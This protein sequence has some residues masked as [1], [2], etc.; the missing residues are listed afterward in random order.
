MLTENDK[1]DKDQ[2]KLSSISTKD[3]KWDLQKKQTQNVAN[4]YAKTAKFARYAER[5][6]ECADFLLFEIQDQQLKLQSARFCHVR[7]CPICQWRKSLRWKAIMYD[8]YSKIK[9]QYPSHRWLFLTLTVKNC[10]ITE[11]RQTLQHMNQSFRRLI[12]RKQFSFIDGVIRTTEVTRDKKHP[13]THAH[14]HFHCILLV[15]SGYFSHSYVKHDQWRWAWHEALRSDYLPSV[16]IRAIKNHNDDKAINGAIAETLKY[17]IKASDIL[18]DGSDAAR[19]WFYEYTKQ[20]HK[21]RFVA[22]S[23]ALKDVLSDEDL[24]DDEMVHI[25]EKDAETQNNASER[26]VFAYSRHQAHYVY[27]AHMTAMVN[28]PPP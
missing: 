17:A 9:A 13:N 6:N 10:E 26:Y 27:N 1:S 19:A 3:Q 2:I 14:P 4:T 24:S 11:L 28:A 15:K 23:G 16:D 5:M 22:T 20:V 8:V 21:L 12:K 18:H 7:N 25:S